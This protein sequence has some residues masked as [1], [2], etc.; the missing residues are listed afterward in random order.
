MPAKT[1]TGGKKNLLEALQEKYGNEYNIEE[2]REAEALSLD[3]LER[4]W[5][6]YADKLVEEQQKHS[7][8]TTFR[9][10]KL[11]IVEDNLFTV[12]VFGTTQQRFIE[13]E[14]IMVNDTIQREFSNRSITFKI[15]VEE[16]V[17]EE[18]PPSQRMNSRE[19]FEHIAKQYPL[20][21]ELK[22]K[23]KLEIDY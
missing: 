10:A 4:I 6:H 14:R 17:K 8:S 7:S 19:R 3:K 22:E 21:K 12:T 20:V 5:L 15:L 11:S 13:Q 9:T 23:L 16:G 2:V 1:G 18:L